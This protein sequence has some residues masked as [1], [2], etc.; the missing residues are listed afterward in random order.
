VSRRGA[1]V[2]S[3]SKLA[4]E[5]RKIRFS[6]V[7]A[8]VDR[9]VELEKFLLSLEAQTYRNFEVIL[10]DQNPD[11]RIKEVL[12]RFSFS[13]PVRHLKVRWKGLSRARNF[14]LRYAK[15]EIVAFP[16]DDCVYNDPYFLSKISDF[17]EKRSDIDL[18]I[19]RATDLGGRDF[20]LQR[21]TPGKVSPWQMWHLSIS[22]VLFA[23]RRVTEKV[24]FDEHLGVG[25]ETPWG[26]GED[27]DFGLRVLK[28]GFSVWYEPT[29]SVAH[30]NKLPGAEKARRY[31]R[32]N[33]YVLRK[34]G[35][36]MKFVWI[37]ARR[38]VALLFYMLMGKWE[39]T[40]W[41]WEALKGTIEGFTGLVR[42]KRRI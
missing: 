26:A 25:S 12:S 2:V 30:P 18:L 27:T 11:E 24:F 40:T 21:K 32:G 8:T 17:L 10:I 6:L 7:L 14:G 31:G 13:F 41:R 29:L 5:G 42:G 19:V 15:G 1:D 38:G 28:A 3:D 20:P 22:W 16:D 9:T 23:L 35:A 36:W 37:M 4:L 33:G 34:H 39:E